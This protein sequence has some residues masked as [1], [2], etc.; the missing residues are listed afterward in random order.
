MPII[1]NLITCILRNVPPTTFYNSLMYLLLSYFN[2]FS[3]NNSLTMKLSIPLRGY[4]NTVVYV[5]Q[6]F[7]YLH[8]ELVN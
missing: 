7:V 5:R 2:F 6:L 3:L 4:P 8:L 1:T